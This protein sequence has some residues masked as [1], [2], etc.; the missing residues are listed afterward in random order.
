M[1]ITGSATIEQ[2]LEEVEKMSEVE[3]QA[4]LIKLRAQKK[5]RNYA[6]IAAYEKGVKQLSMK[7]IDKIKHLSRAK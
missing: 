3:R 7:E 6:P 2:I 1:L 5:R 4:L